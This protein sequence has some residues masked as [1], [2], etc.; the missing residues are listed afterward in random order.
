MLLDKITLREMVLGGAVLGCGGGGTISVG[1][2]RLMEA[3]RLGNPHLVC[4]TELPDNAI[5]ATLSTVGVTKDNS[6]GAIGPRHFLRAFEVFQQNTREKVDGFVA[7]EVGAVSVTY[8]LIE[9]LRADIAVVDAPCN[10]R[11]HPLFVMGSLGLHRL[12]GY[13]PL[14]VACGHSID[15]LIRA[16]IETAGRIVRSE[17][18]INGSS[19][20]VIR[21]PVP[22]G[23]VK[24]HAAVGAL[25]GAIGIGHTITSHLSGADYGGSR[26]RIRDDVAQ[27][28][29]F[30][31][32]GVPR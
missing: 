7:S 26:S 18:A 13:R 27:H 15:F 10:G 28:S 17:V 11:A 6:R 14:V 25:R 8:G 5:L 29:D 20:A 9:S 24:N 16:P 12:R 3:L 30:M 2:T 23:Y 21:N 32:L 4:L 22:V 31:S 19:L 1:L